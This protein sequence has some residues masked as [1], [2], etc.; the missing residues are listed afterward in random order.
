MSTPCF[1]DI[2][3]VKQLNKNIKKG[4]RTQNIYNCR[5]EYVVRS[6]RENYS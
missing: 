3:N 6:T 4:P 5:M 1:S 2:S